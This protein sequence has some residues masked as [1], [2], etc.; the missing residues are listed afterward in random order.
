MH[1]WSQ[2]PRPFLNP[3]KHDLGG[4]P[5]LGQRAS[6]LKQNSKLLIGCHGN[7]VI[8]VWD[9]YRQP[10]TF[11]TDTGS[12][13]RLGRTQAASDVWDRGQMETRLRVNGIESLSIRFE[14][15]QDFNMVIGSDQIWPSISRFLWGWT[16]SGAPSQW[17]WV[18]VNNVLKVVKI[19][20]WSQ[21]V[22]KYDP[23]SPDFYKVDFGVGFEA[24]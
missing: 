6:S 5:L 1:L 23:P 14:S 22:I 19:L 8:D 9:G 12:L 20:T 21:A 10:R 16:P 18:S 4:G 11:G 24:L 15:C 13:G 2:T 17:G 3:Y 7:L